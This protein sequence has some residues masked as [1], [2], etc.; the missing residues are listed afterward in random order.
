MAKIGGP[1]MSDAA[2]GH[3]GERLVFSRRA[4]GQQVRF[5]R[6]Q[7]DIVTLDRIVSRANYSAAVVAWNNLDGIMKEIWSNFSVG[8]GFTG[9]NLFVKM[10]LTGEIADSDSAVFGFRNYGLFIYGKS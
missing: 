9:Y 5:Q 3:I 4:S 6:P 10:Y 2:S 1:L 7:K 8:R